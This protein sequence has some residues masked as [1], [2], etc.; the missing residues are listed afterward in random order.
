MLRILALAEVQGVPV[1]G[2]FESANLQVMAGHIHDGMLEVH[3]AHVAIKARFATPPEF[4]DGK[5][6]V[7]DAPG[8][9]FSLKA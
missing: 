6:Q 5:L 1:T 7:P 3:G 9:G 2:G 4:K 8:L